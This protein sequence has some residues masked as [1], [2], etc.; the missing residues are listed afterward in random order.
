VWETDFT[1]DQRGPQSGAGLLRVDH[2]SQTMPHEQMLSWLLYY[3]S[4]FDVAK[5]PVVQVADPLGLVQTQSI[6]S[7]EG[8]LR[9]LL[10]GSTSQQTLSARFLEGFHGAGTQHIALATA[11][12]IA[13]ARKLRDL[14]LTVLPIPHNYYEDLEARFG[15]EAKL[16]YT[17]EE[18]NILYDRDPDG[19]YFQLV[20]RAFAKRFFFEIVE[21]RGYRS[22][23][24]S[25]ATIRLAA[26]SQYRE[27][28][29]G[30][31]R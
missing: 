9:L 15:L 12:I 16:L 26:Q 13:S 14:G 11:D 28:L 27:D 2:I 6:Q 23:G 21:R 31:V 29:N 8:G 24:A 30:M 7:A 4:L 3:V 20:T 18:L 17:L 10:N 25:N 5:E 22:F 1:L 19:E